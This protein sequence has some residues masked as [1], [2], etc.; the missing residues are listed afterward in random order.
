[1]GN[2]LCG[3]LMLK[4]ADGKEVYFENA[5]I[6]EVTAEPEIMEICD[7]QDDYCISRAVKTNY[8]FNIT[9]RNITRKRFI[10]LLMANGIAK[11]GAK[12]IASYVHKK[13]GQY[14]PIHLIML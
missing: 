4:M 13:Y 1:M 6:N 3:D 9:M 5:I 8:E 11:N 7:P 12:D 14:S 10:K 2:Q